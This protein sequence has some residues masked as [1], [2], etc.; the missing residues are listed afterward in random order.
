MTLSEWLA[1]SDK[2]W[3]T[4]AA[5]LPAAERNMTQAQT[6]A[7]IAAADAEINRLNYD[8]GLADSA[9]QM[10]RITLQQDYW[11]GMIHAWQYVNS[12]GWAAQYDVVAASNNAGDWVSG[13]GDTFVSIVPVAL[14]IT[15]A[16]AGADL[17]AGGALIGSGA[18]TTT[19]TA[20]ATAGTAG[21]AATGADVIATMTGAGVGVSDATIA[22]V[23]ASAPGVAGAAAATA[24]MAAASWGTLATGTVNSVASSI[25]TIAQNMP[26]NLPSAPSAPSVPSVP[27][28]STIQQGEKVG[29]IFD[30]LTGTV[31]QV[32]D[33]AVSMYGAV[34]GV[35]LQRAQ[36]DL[37]TAQ[38]RASAQPGFFQQ[39]NDS[40]GGINWMM[41]AA[42]AAAVLGVA[43][44]MRRA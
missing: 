12:P 25:A 35:Q 37:A 8:L 7:K 9:A 34:Q 17:I 24:E 15:A 28:V 6:E 21:T 38:A 40:Q 27:D 4:L 3:Q 41:L 19:A 14:M 22:A 36:I 32:A 18:A 33:A 43:L 5:T 29:T 13:I 2:S 30:G 20:T 10:K 39:A 26:T 23:A 44:W 31:Q 11:G 42:A 1:S 16:V